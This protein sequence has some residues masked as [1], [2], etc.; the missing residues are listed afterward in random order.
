MRVGLL[1]IRARS[2]TPWCVEA[3]RLLAEG[4]AEAWTPDDPAWEGIDWESGDAVQPDVDAILDRQVEGIA[5]CD[6]LIV[7]LGVEEHGLGA[8]LELG[9]LLWT[10]G[11][12]LHVVLDPEL[13]GRHFIRAHFRESPARVTEHRTVEDAVKAIFA[14]GW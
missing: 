7:R 10:G 5:T 9:R 2:T 12:S 6:S 14:S 11:L 4:G 8:R 1:G 3:A 13:M